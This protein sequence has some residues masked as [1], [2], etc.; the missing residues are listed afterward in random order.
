LTNSINPASLN[1]C[2]DEIKDYFKAYEPD[3]EGLLVRDAINERQELLFRII[4]KI[5]SNE[6]VA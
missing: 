1:N 5:Y 3:D 6:I 4:T 2:T